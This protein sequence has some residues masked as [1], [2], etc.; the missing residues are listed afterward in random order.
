MKTKIKQEN[1][2]ITLQLEGKIYLDVLRDAIKNFY[3]LI[4][5][6]AKEVYREGKKKKPRWVVKDIKMKDKTISII[7]EIEQGE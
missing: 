6:V 7:T 5:N 4:D 3:G 2:L 1:K